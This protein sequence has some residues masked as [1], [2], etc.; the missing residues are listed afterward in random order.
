MG[1]SL[2]GSL[3]TGTDWGGPRG[4]Y[5]SVSN[6]LPNAPGRV[7]FERKQYGVFLDKMDAGHMQRP[8]GMRDQN[9]LADLNE[10]PVPRII[11]NYQPNICL[12]YIIT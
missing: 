1:W 10:I 3:A 5:N 12:K 2:Y 6:S 7:G 9:E 11:V 4:L 8:L